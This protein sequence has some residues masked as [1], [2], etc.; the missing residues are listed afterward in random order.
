[1]EQQQPFARWSL[2]AHARA[3]CEIAR[4]HDIHTGALNRAE[5]TIVWYA[6]KVH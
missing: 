3:K 4:A 2:A 1:M 6:L 5:D